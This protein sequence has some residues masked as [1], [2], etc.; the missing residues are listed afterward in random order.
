MHN[1]DQ[2]VFWAWINMMVFDFAPEFCTEAW[3]STFLNCHLRRIKMKD[4]DKTRSQL[5]AELDELRRQTAALT[6]PPE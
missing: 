1:L 4:E 3:V 5:I 2:P 6:R